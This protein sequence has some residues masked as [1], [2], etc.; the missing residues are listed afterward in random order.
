MNAIAHYDV[1]PALTL[2]AEGKYARNKSFTLGQPS[3]DYYL[4]VEDGNPF[5]P[6]GLPNLG[7]GGV[8][9]TRDNF[10]IGQRGK[11]SRAKPI[12]LSSA[13]GAR[14]TTTP[15]TNCPMSS[16]SRTFRTATSIIPIT[17][18][19]SLRWMR[20][21]IRPPGRSRAA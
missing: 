7:N 8:L 18:G 10:D 11:R 3:F 21:G 12:A 15:A 14:S 9:V 20:C 5:L 13:L 2:F 6:A 17:T 4:L 1:S 19:S 16:A